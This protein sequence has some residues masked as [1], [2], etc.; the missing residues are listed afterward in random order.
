ML[1][2]L[3]HAQSPGGEI[4]LEVKDPSG[5]AMPASGRL[6]NL[7]SG[8]ETSFQSGANGTFT[9]GN[10]SY[11][12]YRLVISSPGFTTQ[13]LLVEV[14]SSRPVLRTITMAL[15]M[16]S[17]KVDVVA[18]TPLAGSGLSA[19]EIPAPVQS[20]TARDLNNSGSLELSDFLN[21]RL[22]GVNINENQEN[23]FQPDLNY[24]GYTASPLLGTPEGISVYMDGVR[25][26]Q[27]FGDVV[28]WD[29]IPRIAISDVTLVPGSNPLFGLNSLG[30]AVSIETKDGRSKP[31]TSISVYGGSFGRRAVEFEHG[32]STSKGLNWYVAGNL[33]HDDGWR[34]R[35]PS[36]VRQTFGKLGWQG[37]KTIVSISFAY[38]DNYLTGN[39]LQ[40]Q[41]FLARNY[42][43]G[44]TYGDTT[45]NRSPFVNLSV[46]HAASGALTFSGNAYFRYIRA[47]SVNP[48]LNTDSLDE[49]VYQPT[50]ADQAALAAAGY[51]GFPTS[52]ANASNTPFPYWRC[53]AQGLQFAEPIEKCDAIIIRSFTKQNNYGISGQLTWSATRGGRRNQF[54]VGA[55]WDRSSLTFQQAAQFGYINPDYTITPINSYEDGSTNSNG[56]PVD[57]RVNLHGLPQT[58]SIYA[59][60]TWSIG[61]TWSF[62]VSGR[63]NRAAID[64]RDRIDPGGGPGSLDG[65]YVFDRLDPSAGVT[66]SPTHFVNL[67]A[68]YAESSRA[69]T[70]IELGC[71]DPDN[72]CNLP[73]ALAGDPP[74][75]QVVTRTFE[76]GVRS[77]Q[78]E[79][80][81]NWSAGWFRATNDN[82]L[83]FVTS[84]VTGNGYFKNFG[85]T[86]RQGAEAHL[87]G[88]IDRVTLGGNY[89]FLRAT[90]ESPETLDGSSNSTNDSAL[91]GSPGMDGVIQIQPG[92]RIPLI[93][94][95]MF[96]AFA[97]AQIT[98]KFSADLDFIAVSSSYARGNE[99]NQSR[100]DGIYYLGP[101]TSPGYG[102]LNLGARYQLQKRVQLFAQ[103]N[104]LL[105]HH[106]FTAAQLGPTGF[107]NQG[108]FIARPLPPVDGN[109]P[110]VHATFYA[111]GA[112]I[113]VWGGIRFSF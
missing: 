46:R 72:P 101:G 2:I 42:A 63:Y 79:S 15:G 68:S 61:N 84:N 69:P 8:A 80:H 48:N 66:F 57:T 90:Y 45:T 76:A 93:P 108:A 30:G 39:G 100:P 12:R 25:Q 64:N 65:Q 86:L 83:L 89:T 24:R 97:D 70:S 23:P 50:A 52:G 62:T 106:Y 109:Y 96:K 102:V 55:A 40:E 38:A 107:T 37:A 9:L 5:A 67:Y 20:A 22:N 14:Q 104:N 87:S 13:S 32:G 91:A 85:Q 51:T 73:N 92:D 53:I 6:E 28:S 99:N 88:R 3:S 7:R 44:Y 43:S 21:R 33:L 31:G 18:A 47:D 11:G 17:A 19:L 78:G 27:P 56:T 49:S 77:G 4:R 95:H 112:P 34:I 71:A 111:P 1:P 82:D 54:T 105:D 103:I 75:K 36:D 74:L 98:R 110:I 113:G 29:L 41:R 81:L 58:W 26:N 10:L 35:S 16:E 94:Q 60:D 59:T